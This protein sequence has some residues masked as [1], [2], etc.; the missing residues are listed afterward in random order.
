MRPT[1]SARA[2]KDEAEPV[3]GAWCA[4]LAAAESGEGSTWQ[5]AVS[6]VDAPPADDL[7]TLIGA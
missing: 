6:A 5:L 1:W 2:T 3:L 7:A 4:K